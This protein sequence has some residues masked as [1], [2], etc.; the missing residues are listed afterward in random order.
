[1]GCP[2]ILIIDD[3]HSLLRLAQM[4]LQ[5]KKFEVSVALSVSEAKSL[6]EV[7]TPFDLII[8][9]LMMPDEN[10]FDFLKWK[11]AQEE[12]VRKIPVIVNT[13]KNITEEDRKILD[14]C[15]K[16]VVTKGIDFTERLIAEV[17]ALLPE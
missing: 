11:E 2:R 7:E 9:D 13:A 5:K 6:I 17:E 3:E 8:L 14:F 15:C 1:M 12:N 10:G 16:T 4:I